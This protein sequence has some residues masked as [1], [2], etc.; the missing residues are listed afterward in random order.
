MGNLVSITSHIT[1]LILMGIPDGHSQISLNVSVDILQELNHTQPPK[2]PAYRYP[3]NKQ[4]AHEMVL[5]AAR[6]GRYVHKDLSHQQNTVKCSSLCTDIANSGSEMPYASET[7]YLLDRKSPQGGFSSSLDPSNSAFYETLDQ[8]IIPSTIE[9][10]QAMTVASGYHEHD[11]ANFSNAATTGIN[12]QLHTDATSELQYKS[13]YQDTYGQSYLEGETPLQLIENPPGLPNPTCYDSLQQADISMIEK[14]QAVL[15]ASKHRGPMTPSNMPK[16]QVGLTA[17]P[18]NHLP[19]RNR[20]ISSDWLLYMP[21]EYNQISESSGEF[22]SEA[23]SFSDY[24]GEI[25][26]EEQR[27]QSWR[28][29]DAAFSLNWPLSEVDGPV[30][31]TE[32]V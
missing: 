5:P 29:D 1:R 16:S 3:K 19:I 2:K 13:T 12:M 11:F 32:R 7:L 25:V 28:R 15:I 30:L 18:P 22:S 14:E 9:A 31:I 4:R 20:C 10:E 8:P 17:W 21:N 26:G 27:W 6:S 24:S 23:T